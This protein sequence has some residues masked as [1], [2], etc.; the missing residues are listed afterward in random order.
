VFGA[1]VVNG[2]AS[3][4]PDGGHPPGPPGPPGPVPLPDP[5]DGG[6]LA[7]AGADQARLPGRYGDGDQGPPGLVGAGLGRLP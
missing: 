7:E 5:P 1:G 4:Q 2:L 3:P 6:R